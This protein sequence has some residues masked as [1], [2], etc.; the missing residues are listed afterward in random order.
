MAFLPL[1]VDALQVHF[2]CQAVQLLACT[3]HKA[4]IL[5]TRSDID[6][7]QG[8]Q[9]LHLLA[10]RHQELLQPLVIHLE[11]ILGQRDDGFE[12]GGLARVQLELRELGREVQV[13]RSLGDGWTCTL[14]SGRLMVPA[15]CFDNFFGKSPALQ[16][17]GTDLGMI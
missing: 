11:M 8:S 10:Q 16:E 5:L 14:R 1:E 7:E 13:Q 12:Q 9:L 4:G 3:G 6:L 2:H 17:V 15:D